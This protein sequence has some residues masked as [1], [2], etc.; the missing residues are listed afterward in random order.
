[1][2]SFKFSFILYGEECHV[3]IFVSTSFHNVPILFGSAVSVD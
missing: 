3:P 1:M 2:K